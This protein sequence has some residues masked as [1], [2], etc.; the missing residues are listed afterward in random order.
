MFKHWNRSPG[1]LWDLHPWSLVLT[2]QVLCSITDIT[3]LFRQLNCLSCVYFR[4]IAT[5]VPRAVPG[6]LTDHDPTVL[7]SLQK[8]FQT[9]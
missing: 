8:Q 2:S 1:E 9:G 6:A 3:R 4:N 7:G 5:M